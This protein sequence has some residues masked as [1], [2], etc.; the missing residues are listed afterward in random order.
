MRKNLYTD[1]GINVGTGCTGRS[2]RDSHARQGSR[3]S[4]FAH[5]LTH[6][7]V[8]ARTCTHTRSHART[9][10][11]T[12]AST[13]TRTHACKYALT[14]ARMHARSHACTH[15]HARTHMHPGAHACAHVQV[16][17]SATPAAAMNVVRMSSA[18]RCISDARREAEPS[19]Y[20]DLES[21]D[22]DI[23]T[24]ALSVRCSRRR[25]STSMEIAQMLRACGSA[26]SEAG[27][28]S[29]VFR[30]YLFPLYL[31]TLAPLSPVPLI[32]C[33]RVPL[34][35]CVCPLCPDTSVCPSAPLPMFPC[36]PAPLHP[37]T[38]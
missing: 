14:Y 6:A 31:S 22:D 27:V 3:E 30:L 2:D 25:L 15:T 20:V 7:R 16:S 17:R 18:A 9:H 32:F 33:T 1:I 8:R 35:L 36:T 11:D 4:P 38:L 26:P 37:C 23:V 29:S 28:Q 12:H 34:R 10:S 5:L 24:P 19:A 21:D 13:H